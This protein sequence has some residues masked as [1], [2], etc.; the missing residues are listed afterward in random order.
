M[1]DSDQETPQPHEDPPQGEAT[2][3]TQPA[4]EASQPNVTNIEQILDVEVEVMVRF[5][6]VDMPLREV[7][8]LSTG[9]ILELDRRADE[10]VELLLNNAV[11]ATG[12]VVVADGNYALRIGKIMS[13]ADRVRSLA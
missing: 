1:T 7:A 13:P 2:Q 11:F 12:E 6:Q 10:P 8:R 3:A 9:S 5:G 4:E